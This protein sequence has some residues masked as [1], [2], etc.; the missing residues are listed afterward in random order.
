MTEAYIRCKESADYL[1]KKIPV[2]PEIGIVLGSALGDFARQIEDPVTI[3][4]EEIPNFLQSTAPGHAGK[5]IFGRICGKQVV[6]MSGRFHS[7]EGYDFAQLAH[8]VR[9]L[10]L[11][12]IR[13]LVLT[14]AAGGVNRAY[15][16]G[17]VMIIR[18][19]IMF[20]GFS[21]MRGENAA[22]FGPRFF[23]TTNTYP[24]H[25]RELAL[26]CGSRSDLRVHEGVYFFMQGP[27]FETPAEIRAI[28]V[29]GGDAVGMSTV[30]P[31]AARTGEM[32]TVTKRSASSRSKIS[33]SRTLRT[34]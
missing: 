27:Q 31:S 6:C 32:G 11:L 14:N 26:Y 3:G 17:D 13:L 30:P 34:T 1:L 23:D 20:S 8:P 33:L 5:L 9:V 4:Y 2:L 22:E 25:L 28:S 19:H 24:K 12:G 29:L 10:K 15:R 18:D 7:Y 21:P 16:P